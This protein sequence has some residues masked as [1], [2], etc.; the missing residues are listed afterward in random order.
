MSFHVPGICRVTLGSM[1]SS[2]KDGNN[3]M[4][5][6]RMRGPGHPM[7]KVIAS[8]GMGWE[9]VSVSF[10]NRCPTWDEMCRIKNIFWDA[11]DCVVQYHP[12]ASEYVNNHNFCLHLWRPTNQDIP[13][14]PSFMVGIPGLTLTEL[15]A[16]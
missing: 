16:P 11:G 7:A 10:P 12:P 2:D 1:G 14:P 15:S 6:V 9:H 13:R 5:A 3:G 4:F 8:D